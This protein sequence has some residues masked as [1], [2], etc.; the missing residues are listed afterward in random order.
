MIAS[1]GRRVA[2]A[3]HD[4]GRCLLL[5]AATIARIP[6]APRMWRRI[7]EQVDFAGFG[8]LLVLAMISAMTGMIMAM[9]MGP[10]LA[11]YGQ[12]QELGGIIASTFT[13]ELGAVWAAVIILG[14]VGS[15]MAAELGTMTVNEEV[16]ALRV[17]DIDPVRFLVLP[18]IAAL[19]IVMPLLTML[20]DVMGVFG[21]ALVG[22]SLFG[23]DFDD[24]LESAQYFVGWRFFSSGII[25]SF[26][27]ALVIGAIACDQGLNCRGGAE[28]VGR[29]TTT[30]VRLSVMFILIVDLVLTAVIRLTLL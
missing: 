19:V 15:A 7:L 10:T 3:C 17:M 28:G 14:R 5:L 18:R 1:T 23:V 21:G 24:F 16:E 20:A 27:F 9:Q 11:Y 12:M 29:A 13:L 22:R 26:A 6:Q 2:V 8:S 4:A 25:K 30:A